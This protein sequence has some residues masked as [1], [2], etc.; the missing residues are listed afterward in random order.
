MKSC[1]HLLAEV[2]ATTAAL[3][4]CNGTEADE[5]SRQWSRLGCAQLRAGCCWP[6]DIPHVFLLDARKRRGSLRRQLDPAVWGS[7][8][9][10]YATAQGY[11]FPWGLLV[12]D[13]SALYHGKACVPGTVFF[14][15]APTT[16]W[17]ATREYHSGLAS[18][19]P[20]IL[21]AHAYA[22]AELIWPVLPQ[23]VE[24]VCNEPYDLCAF[25]GYGVAEAKT[26]RSWLARRFLPE[27][28]PP[29]MNEVREKVIRYC[30]AQT[31]L[32]ST[33]PL[34]PTRITLH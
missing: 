3:D 27:H 9:A 5:F 18:T 17:M 31:T 16:L 21:R 6:L 13:R 26:T 29:I 14:R 4:T 32:P 20:E 34:R 11:R 28:L 33:V 30:R 15:I 7:L 25:A 1:V 10:Q 2:C 24:L 22:I 23:R 19:I 12:E 8:A